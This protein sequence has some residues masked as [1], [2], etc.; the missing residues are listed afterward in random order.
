MSIPYHTNTLQ[1]F[2]ISR[3]LGFTYHLL[4]QC[5]GAPFA[6]P[7]PVCSSTQFYLPKI[8]QVLT[9]VVPSIFSLF[10]WPFCFSHLIQ[11]KKQVSVSRDYSISDAERRSRLP[12]SLCLT[13][14]LSLKISQSGAHK[15]HTTVRL[16]QKHLDS[17]EWLE[18]H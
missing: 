9:K 11:M 2:P 7:E 13:M 1:A 14:T 16:Y 6:W 3:V 10:F 18:R 4:Q 12:S 15:G 5:H 17:G 8:E